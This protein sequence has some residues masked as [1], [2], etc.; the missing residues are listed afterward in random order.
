MPVKPSSQSSDTELDHDLFELIRA[1]RPVVAALK[2][3]SPPPAIF[4]EAFRRG[5]LG[6]R[7]GPVLMVVAFEG[8]QS[9]SDIAE[10]IGLSLS[11]TSLLVG[12]LDRAGLLARQEDDRDRRRTL[13]GLSDGYREAA[14]TW[15]QARVTPLRRTLER[16][17]PEE[18]AGF[19]AGWRVL[20]EEIGA[21]A[22]GG[23][24]EPSAEGER[25]PEGTAAS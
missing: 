25:S 15:L 10:R 2:R 3:G 14:E 4:E 9:V 21:A 23:P 7:H 20:Q 22:P 19:I 1:V 5:G 11:T 8:Q 12:E 13:V 6:P 16:L 18:R 17:T 24:G